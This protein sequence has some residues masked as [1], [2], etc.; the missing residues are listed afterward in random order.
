MLETLAWE[1][2]ECVGYHEEFAAGDA[3]AGAY[4]CYLTIAAPRLTLLPGAPAAYVRPAARDHGRPPQSLVDPF[5]VPLLN[6]APVVA[7]LVETVAEAAAA[8]VLAPIA[9]V[10]A[11]ILGST[12]PAHAPGLPH[13]HVPPANPD[14]L[15]LHELVARHATGALTAGEE[16]ELIALLTKVKGIHVQKLGD[17]EK[18]ATPIQ[19]ISSKFPAEAMP[20]DGKIVPYE[21]VD[22]N[23]KGVNGRKQF[24]FVV[25]DKGKLVIG[26]KHHMLA[27]GQPVQAAGQ[28]RLN[29]KGQIRQID[30]LSGH[31]QPSVSE[32]ANYPRI[33]ESAGVKVKGATIVS[34]SISTNSSGMVTGVKV[35]SS[36][37]IR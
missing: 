6:P 7:P 33:L 11:L 3:D 14:E 12:T 25:Y 24:D 5:V 21:I 9:L 16:A 17:L 1:A 2:G 36:R 4:V 26:N 37:V 15:R 30:N 27:H 29:G 31:Y 23:I 20:A 18:L 8:T 13:P 22:G 35:V 10:L 34:H 19:Q 28:L 32:T